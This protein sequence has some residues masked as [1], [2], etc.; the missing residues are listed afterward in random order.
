MIRTESTTDLVPVFDLTRQ[1]QSLRADLL[2]T[3]DRV[4]SSG[5]YILGR[6]VSEFENDFARFVG[7][8]HCVGTNSGTSALHLALLA[9]G[10]TRGHEVITTPATWISTSWAISYVGARPVFVDI[11][12]RTCC[13][14]PNRIESAISPRT[15]AILVVH[16][17]GQPADMAAITSLADRYG[18]AVIEDAAQAHG[19]RI[20]GQHVG[21]FG[22]VGC[23]SFYP[24]KNLGATG[25]AGA[26]VTDD[27]AIADQV[28][29]LRDHGQT[30]RHVHGE[31]GF[32]MRMEAMQAA[33][34]SV[35]LRRLGEWLSARRFIA[36]AYRQSWCGLSGL[37]IPF[38][39]SGTSHAW[40]VFGLRSARR[41]ELAAHLHSR[42]VATAV[43]YPTP[44][45]LQPAYRS[46]GCRR[47]DF[48]IAERLSDEELTIPLFPE[49]TTAE[50]NRVVESV[51]EWSRLSPHAIGSAA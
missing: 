35:K 47:G 2:E 32:N 27:T 5:S 33:V 18:L 38:E 11:D 1:Y 26:I 30:S 48:P 13:L 8:A 25:E 50:M 6:F 39:A 49:L 20:A 42:G 45:H 10:V 15:K 24:T 9:A 43:H 44:V 40:H 22:R 28:R 17:Y 36:Q 16:L 21:T 12:S 19:A 23:F 34:L 31:I 41:D 4:L 3:I 37:Q 51:C 46:L 29:R 14:D 7:A